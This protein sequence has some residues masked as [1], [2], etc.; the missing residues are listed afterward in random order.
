MSG[1]FRAVDRFTVAMAAEIAA[2]RC[3]KLEHISGRK[4]WSTALFWRHLSMYG[5]SCLVAASLPF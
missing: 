3:D 5:A 2:T 4:E 1:R